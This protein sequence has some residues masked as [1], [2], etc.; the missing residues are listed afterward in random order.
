ME[1]ETDALK[2]KELCVFCFDVLVDH[3]D[4]SKKEVEFPI[5]FKGVKIK[6]KFNFRNLIQ[7]SLRGQKEKN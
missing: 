6:I 4:K 3:L 7:Y 2:Y 1:P 5:Y